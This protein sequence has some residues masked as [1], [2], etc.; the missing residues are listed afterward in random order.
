MGPLNG[1]RVV[2]LAGL[3]PGPFCGM[4][5]ADM[6]AEVIRST[7]TSAARQPRRR[8][9]ASVAS[10]PLRSTSRTPRASRPC[11]DL[12]ASADA[13]IEGFRPGV[14]ERLGLGPE[15]CLARNPSLVYGR[16]TGWGQNGPLAQRP[17]TTSTTSRSPARCTRS[18]EAGE[19]RCR[20]S[21]WWA[22]SAA[23]ACC[24]PSASCARCS[25]RNAR[26]R[27]RWSTPAMVDGA[28]ALM[29]MLFHVHAR[30][31]CGATSAA[32]TCS[33]AARTSTT[34]TRPKDGKYISIGS[35]EP[36]FYALLLEKTGRR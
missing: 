25:R 28:A 33:T 12:V 21:T 31:A 5:L 29:H 6:G 8:R 24:W 32:P 20:R 9:S 3:G 1:L 4:M 30:R 35:I 36:Q 27:A 23:A 2:E 7:R 22:T 14:M 18:G 16:M 13:L 19:R 10:R 15:A 11:C 17:A 26:A 34:P